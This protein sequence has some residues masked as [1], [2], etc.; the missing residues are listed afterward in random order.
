M[1]QKKL[2]YPFNEIPAELLKNSNAV[3]REDIAR[4]EIFHLGKAK[5]YAKMAIT[6]LNKK[7]DRFAEVRVGYDKLNKIVSLKGQRYDR[8]GRL[9]SQLKNKDIQ[10][11]S[12]YDGYSIYTDNRVKYFDLRY[13]EYPYTVVYEYEIEENGFMSLSNW[14]PFSGFNMSSQQS[15]LTI[16]TPQDYTFKYH[17]LNIEPGA[18]E[19]IMDGK[20]ITTWQFGSY[21]AIKREPYMPHLQSILPQVITAPTDFEL[22]GYKGSMADWASFGRW[23]NDLNAGRDVLPEAY[24]QKVKDLVAGEPSRTGKIKLLYK[25]LQSNTRYISVQLGI[26]GWQTFPAAHVAENGYGDCKALTNFMKA[27]L[28]TIDIDSYYTLVRAGSSS[29]EIMKDFPSNQFN[30]MI[31]CVPNYNDTI[32]LE[33]TS[34]DNP[35]GYLGNF[36]GDRDVLVINENGGRITRTK[37]FSRNE[38]MQVQTTEVA[39]QPGGQANVLLTV[40]CSGLQYDN[41]ARLIDIGEKEQHKWLFKNLDIPTFEINNLKLARIEQENPEL[42]MEVDVSIPRFASVSGKRIFIEPNVFNQFGELSKP[43][44]ER[45]YDFVL[46]FPY[47]DVDTVRVQVPEGYHVEFLPEKTAFDTEFGNYKSEIIS[48]QGQITYI[49]KCSRTEGTFPAKSYEEY[50][51]FVNKIAEADKI[52][53]VLVRSS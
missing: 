48:E 37:S 5:L 4:Y 38:N 25:H 43:Q 41:Y 11:F 3:I 24:A 39:L 6:I 2:L 36:T 16:I 44:N 19:D 15:S 1:G 33:C 13:A 49:R 20:K 17:E 42:T 8:N 51:D 9:I 52:K 46:K 18:K 12:S 29:P 53:I 28:K 14:I 34:Q 23:E 21:P 10:D 40:A 31:L 50:V 30:H 47:T 26:G 32:W 22:E 7:G 35:F 45:N 27:M